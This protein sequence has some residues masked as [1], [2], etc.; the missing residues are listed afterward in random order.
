[1]E[2]ADLRAKGFRLKWFDVDVPC[3]GCTACC[4]GEVALQPEL[5]DNPAEYRTEQIDGLVGKLIV[6]QRNAD[7]TCVYLDGDKCSIWTR[8]P[9]RC[10]VFDC[11]AYAQDPMVHADPAR[12]ERVIAA[13]LE[14]S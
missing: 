5:G 4:H 12:D 11:R 7:D 10:R 1:V 14:R 2:Y 3:N 13:G 8:R 6:L 9:W